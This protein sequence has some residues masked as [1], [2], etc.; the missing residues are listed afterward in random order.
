MRLQDVKPTFDVFSLG[1]LLWAMV[2]GRP[3]FPLWYFDRD[4]HDLWTLL[5]DN[6]DVLFVQRILKKCVVEQSEH[7]LLTD[8]AALLVEIDLSIQ[9]L[10]AGAVVPTK[11]A[12]M[13]CRFCGI[14]SY[15]EVAN[16][17]AHGDSM[18]GQDNHYFVCDQCG[19]LQT[20]VYLG[21]QTP[22]AWK[23]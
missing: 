14:G 11:T 7:C 16:F 10:S 4:P 12:R 17:R 21:K 3:R 2:S 13:R 8:A 6:P 5:P 22:L 9:A 23:D 19:Q 15:Q 18:H 20:F 1:K